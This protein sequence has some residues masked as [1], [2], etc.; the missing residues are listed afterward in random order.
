MD[1]LFILF[2][3]FICGWTVFLG[4]LASHALASVRRIPVRKHLADHVLDRWIGDGQVDRLKLGEDAVD[5]FGQRFADDKQA[6]DPAVDG[7]DFTVI[8]R[9]EGLLLRV[10]GQL[11]LDLA[12]RGEGLDDVVK[13]AV[14]HHAAVVDDDDPVTQRGDVSHVV[15]GEQDGG[16]VVAVVAAEEAADG[17]LGVDVQAERRLVEEQHLRPVQQRR[18]QFALHPLAQR[19][20]ADRAVELGV[21]A[22]HPGQFV[23]AAFGLV[24]GHVVD[25]GVDVQRVHRGQVPHELLLLAHDQRDLPQEVGLAVERGVA[26][27]FGPAAAGMDQ[28]GEHL[29]RGGLARAVRAEEP[30]DF[31]G[32]DLEARLLDGFD[33]VVLAIKKVPHGAAQ[34]RLFV[35]D[36]I[37]LGELIRNDDG[38]GRDSNP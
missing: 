30:D 23:D 22:E 29:E 9:L 10:G 21:E 11:D 7:F 28:P 31:A 37:S 16:A 33:V 2:V 24:V 12:E 14:V 13:T 3:L 35:R 6:D 36:A 27:D 15:A 19:E 25:R 32:A 18:D 38:H 8:P 1:G 17:G 34:P 4:V 5:G 20:F 26:N